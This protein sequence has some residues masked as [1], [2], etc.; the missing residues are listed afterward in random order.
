MRRGPDRI[1]LAS[2]GAT[3]ARNEAAGGYVIRHIYRTDPDYPDRL[4]PLV[5]PEVNLQ[6]GDVIQAINGIATLD[7]TFQTAAAAEA[8]KEVVALKD[9]VKK[10]NEA[11]AD[12]KKKLDEKQKAVKPAASSMPSSP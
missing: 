4:S 11:I 2:L 3:L 5:T 10:A 1:D 6:E 12:T 7:V 9:R 8:D